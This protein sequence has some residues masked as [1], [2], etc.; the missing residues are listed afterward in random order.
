MLISN[1][2]R[3][4]LRDGPGIRTTVFTKGCSLRCVWCHNPETISQEV[5]IQLAENRCIHCGRCGEICRRFEPGGGIR[6]D[7]P[8]CTGCG[9]CVEACPVKALSFSGK[10]MSAAE[11]IEAAERDRPFFENSGG[12][13]TISGGEPLMQRDLPQILQ[14]L[15]ERGVHTAVDTAMNVPWASIEGVLPYTSL[16]LADLKALDE[17]VHRRW[18]GSGNRLI[19]ENFRRLLNTSAEIWVR[20]PFIPGAN[21]EEMPKIAAYLKETA[22]SRI[23]LEVIPFHNYA[24]NKYRSLGMTYAFADVQPPEDVI[25]QRC[26]RLFDGLNIIRYH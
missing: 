6:I 2:Q 7:A 21:D 12:G 18:T 14:A 22:G 11:L 5:Q 3:F 13:V 19:L 4:S 25:Y 20:V 16:F 15:R 1:I 10:E 17:S 8:A 26:L 9:R 23:S 24:F